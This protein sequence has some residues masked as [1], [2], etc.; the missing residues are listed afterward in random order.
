MTYTPVVY[1]WRYT[2][3]PKSQIFMAGGGSID[4]GMTIGG[5]SVENPEPGGRAELLLEFDGIANADANV[6]ASFL[7]SK[8]MRGAIFRI[9]LF[10]PTL[11][12]V[13]DSDLAG[14]TSD[15]VTFSGGATFSDGTS[16]AYDPTG[17][18]LL[19]G[20]AGETTLY[21][22]FDAVATV[23]R[24]GHI[25]GVHADGYDFTHVI[26]DIQWVTSDR[27]TITIE[28]PLRRRV[29]SSDFI[30]YRPTF[31]GTCVNAREAVGNFLYGRVMQFA[32][33]RFVEALV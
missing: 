6:D 30:K 21:V 22:D 15:G 26:T 10:Y 27:A 32:P 4:G 9:R 1:D 23:I 29:T 28:P 17:N 31:T 8:L 7:A 12:M 24:V 2:V 20:L 13:Q 19:G 5:A 16:F 3:Q 18:I 33:M 11:Q 25:I 14:S